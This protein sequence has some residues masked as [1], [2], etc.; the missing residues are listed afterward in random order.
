MNRRWNKVLAH[1][2]IWCMAVVSFPF[3]TASN[4]VYAEEPIEAPV[5]KAAA[6][7]GNATPERIRDGV[8]L[9][10]FD[11]NLSVIQENLQ[12][13][14]DAGY[15]AIQT[16]PIMGSSTGGTGWASSYSPRNMVA[17]GNGNK[18]GDRDAFVS[19]TSAANA[20]G[21]KVVVDVIP[22]H[23]GSAANSDAPWNDSTYFHNVTGNV[24]YNDRFLLTQPEMIS[25]LRDLDTHA[26]FVQDAYIAYLKDIIDAG[27]SGFRYDAIK[28]IELDDDAPSPASIAAGAANPRYTDGKFA[29]DYVKNVTGAVKAYLEAKGKVN[30]QYG[31]VLQG[32]RP[33]HGQ[34]ARLCQVCRPD[35]LQ[36]RA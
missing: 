9:H 18:F 27:A 10:A 1:V 17:G 22:N 7:T 5:A 2:L 21:I 4:P 32:G 20:L 30:F 14:A 31:E 34:D 11:W 19:L 12:A 8:I 6:T 35:R 23:M 15:T 16:S 36:V 13:I 24:G 29:S 3:V 26:K 28:H 25:G 33:Q